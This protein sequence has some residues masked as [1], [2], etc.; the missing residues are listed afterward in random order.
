LARSARTEGSRWPDDQRLRHGAP[1]DL[2]DVG[3]HADSLIPVSSSTPDNHDAS[4]RKA[5]TAKPV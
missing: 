3:G 1:E 5:L 2:D 4:I